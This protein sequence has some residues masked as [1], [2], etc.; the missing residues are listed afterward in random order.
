MKK[1]LFTIIIITAII[2]TTCTVKK[3]QT[4]NAETT[5]ETNTE[6][7]AKDPWFTTPDGT[8]KVT[9]AT[10]E[11]LISMNKNYRYVTVNQTPQC[12][13][14]IFTPTIELRDFR[15]TAI[16][17]DLNHEP[18]RIIERRIKGSMNLTPQDAIIV[19]TFGLFKAEMN[20]RLLLTIA[21]SP[22]IIFS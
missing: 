5:K 14:L 17:M 11:L 13:M 2:L 22:L 7:T 1:H 12:Q 20:S 3:L 6:T 15:Y 18:L 4:N 19:A 9:I 21:I 16:E 8:L 10:D